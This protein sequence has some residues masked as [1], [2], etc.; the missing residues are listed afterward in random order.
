MSF[1]AL[2]YKLTRAHICA[3]VS[4]L[5]LGSFALLNGATTPQRNPYAYQD[6]YAI[7]IKEMRD[8]IDDLR[9]EVSNHET[10]IRSFD[11]KLTNFESIM[12]SIR[13]QFQDVSKSH[14]EQLKGS[15]ANLESKITFLENTSKGLIADLKQFKTHANETSTVLNQFKEK[16]ESIEKIVTQQSQDMENL[17]AAMQSLMEALQ[18]KSP[19]SS[20]KKES[21]TSSSQTSAAGLSYKV[22]SGDSLEKIAKNHQVTIQALKE[23]NGLTTDRIVVGKNLIIPEK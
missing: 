12:E 11:E 13:D 2:F 18:V 17:Q 9:H 5:M 20:S 8:S 14:K 1:Q 15:S 4:F 21:K 6:G 7:A 16:I 3:F 22:K 10:E 23:A 19:S